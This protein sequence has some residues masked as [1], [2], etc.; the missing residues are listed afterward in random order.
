MKQ[1][2]IYVVVKIPSPLQTSLTL[3]SE[4]A[5]AKLPFTVIHDMLVPNDFTF[6]SNMTYAI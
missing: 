6:R 4:L 5:K 2:H 3:D 1:R